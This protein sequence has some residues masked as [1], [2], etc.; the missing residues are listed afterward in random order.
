MQNLKLGTSL[1]ILFCFATGCSS[2]KTAKNN[3]NAWLMGNFAAKRFPSPEMIKAFEN[4]YADPHK[5]ASEINEAAL[6]GDPKAVLRRNIMIDE[7]LLISDFY[8]GDFTTKAY[9]NNSG[10]NSVFDLSS[11]GLSSAATV[12]GGP[13]GQALSATDTGLKAAQGKLSERWLSS[14]TVPALIATMDG[15]RAEELA[16]INVQRKLPFEKFTAMEA[17]RAVARY[18]QQASLIRAMNEIEARANEDKSKS[19]TKA[20]I[21]DL[22]PLEST[23]NSKSET[24]GVILKSQSAPNLF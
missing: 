7:L 5:A 24:T 15:L 6:S 17:L 1:L 20:A 18:H 8:Y 21:A 10:F 9:V 13:V 2:V 11:I 22:S 19:E 4:K 16:F 3:L 23:E 12:V 14:R